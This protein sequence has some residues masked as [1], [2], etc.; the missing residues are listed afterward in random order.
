MRGMCVFWNTSRSTNSENVTHRLSPLWIWVDIH[1]WC[2]LKLR[3]CTWG[4]DPILSLVQSPFEKAVRSV[5]IVASS[6]SNQLGIQ[7]HTNTNL[8]VHADVPQIPSS[9]HHKDHLST[10]FGF[11][12]HKKFSTLNPPTTPIYP[13]P[14]TSQGTLTM[15]SSVVPIKPSAVKACSTSTTQF[16]MK[17]SGPPPR[18]SRRAVVPSGPMPAAEAPAGSTKLAMLVLPKLSLAMAG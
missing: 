17:T 3:S 7:T 15:V 16:V 13:F 2:D 8:T 5:N 12:S 10:F 18:N 9:F 1:R 14:P 11:G 4:I 6:S